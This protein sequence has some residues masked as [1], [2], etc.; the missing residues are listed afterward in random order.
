MLAFG[1]RT[2]R[3]PAA[4]AANT[5]LSESSTTRQLAGSIPIRSAASR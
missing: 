5:P 4:R 2:T 3:I 1:T